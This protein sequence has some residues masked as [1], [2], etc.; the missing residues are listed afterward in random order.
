MSAE[1]DIRKASD[2]FYAALNCVLNGDWTPMGDVWSRNPG[3]STM[4]PTGGTQ[5]GWDEIRT[6]W[7]NLAKICSNGRVELSDQRI[8]VGE[9]LAYETGTEHVNVL[10]GK[11]KAQAD[12]RVSN[13][14]RREGSEW[15]MVHHHVDLNQ[16]M[17]AIL[18]KLE[19]GRQT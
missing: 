4:H 7:E 6:S 12:F 8:S 13:V 9:D 11:D 18:S 10:I 1:N 17:L 14:F 5:V 2:K 16:T 15:R 3:V 19:T